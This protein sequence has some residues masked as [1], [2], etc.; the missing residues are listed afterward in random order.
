GIQVSTNSNLT[1]LAPW[2]AERCVASGLGTLHVSID[3]ATAAT[4]ER[5]RVRAHFARV[6]RNLE[7][8]HAARARAGSDLPQLRMVSV[9]MR[10]NLHELPGLVT[11]AHTYRFEM[12]SVQHLCHDFGEES[13][14]P[15]YRPMRDFVQ[16]QSLLG[17]DPARV[18]H[19]FD[20]A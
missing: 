18:T 8:L 15:H 14:P 10:E 13:L 6:I 9:V 11:L 12:L 4:Y 19:F 16:Q 5:I 3:G 7:A 1:L 17:E 2:R 20:A